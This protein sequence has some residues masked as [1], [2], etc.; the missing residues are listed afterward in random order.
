MRRT[1]TSAAGDRADGPVPSS[2]LLADG[3]GMLCLTLLTGLVTVQCPFYPGIQVE[4]A[5]LES[6]DLDAARKAA[7]ARLADLERGRETLADYGLD[8]PD[9]SGARLNLADPM[10]MSR[11][12]KL[13]E[14]VE[15]CIL[16]VKAWTGVTLDRRTIAPIDR[17]TLSLVMRQD[18]FARWLIHEIS[19]AARILIYE[20]K[21]LG[22]SP[23][24]SS[25]PGA[26]VSAP[27]T[28]HPAPNATSPAPRA[29]RAR[30]PAASARSSK[31]PRKPSR[32]PASGG[33]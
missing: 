27:P 20:K 30:A 16:A 3:P 1:K 2:R 15:V 14:D 23:T 21:D 7:L 33:S 28:A 22:P 6:M 5:R 10:Q 29:A 32:A 26:T 11:L 18:S 19:L 25:E 24:G 9:A 8:G 13:L 31:P 12:G 4:I 17:A